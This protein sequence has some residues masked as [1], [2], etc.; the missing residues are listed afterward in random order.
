MMSKVLSGLFSAGQI[1]GTSGYEEAAAQGL[2]AGVNAARF[3]AGEEAVSLGRDQGYIGVMTDDLVRWGLSEPYR[4]LTSRNEY[5]LLH[6]QDNADERLLAVGQAWGLQSR[7][8]L[9]LLQESQ[10]RVEA[11]VRRLENVRVDG[12]LASKLLCRPGVTYSDLEARL[13][14]ANPT[15]LEREKHKVEVAVKYASYIERS[16]RELE[17][18]KG[19]EAITLGGI[20]YERVS[21]L[22]HEGRE[23][24]TKARP[25]T[26]G[27]AQ[28]LRGVRDS[29]V[30][31]LLVFCKG[32]Q[33]GT[34]VSRETVV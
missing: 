33:R 23:A 6:R 32:A 16:R 1:N 19:Y 18:R 24:L 13:G 8:A 4:M 34:T 28:R 27:A 3:A 10:V 30:T 17:S 15:L 2:I 9:E 25:A 22:S 12:I 29:D 31:A 11:E 26:L 14:G 7:E 20:S 5:R 21:S